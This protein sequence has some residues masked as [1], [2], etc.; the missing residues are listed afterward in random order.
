[1]NLCILGYKFCVQHVRLYDEGDA[2]PVN[3]VVGVVTASTTD[4]GVEPSYAFESGND[5]EIFEISEC[6]GTIF[7]KTR[8][9]T[10]AV[11]W[12]TI[13]VVR[14]PRSLIQ[15]GRRRFRASTHRYKTPGRVISNLRKL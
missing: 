2:A 14:K 15:A 5:D 4:I 1:M 12:M 7:L 8:N 9:G 10:S 3:H 6:S 11:V 13:V